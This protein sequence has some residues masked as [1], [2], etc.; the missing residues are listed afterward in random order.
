MHMPYHFLSKTF[1]FFPSALRVIPFGGGE[2]LLYPH[3][4]ELVESAK[5]YETEVYFNTNATMLTKDLAR[6]LVDLDVDRI[7]FSVDG[8]TEKT[9][10]SIR[11]G[12]NLL[13][14]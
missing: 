9:F 3:F 14:L 4:I 8:A 6:R 10:E 7:S 1:S 12:A 5:R 13:Q 11:K 2:P